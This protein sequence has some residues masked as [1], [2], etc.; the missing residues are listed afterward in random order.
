MDFEYPKE[1]LLK[2]PELYKGGLFNIHFNFASFL[3]WIFFAFFKAI[4]LIVIS[5]HEFK[6]SPKS[7][8]GK[9]AGYAELGDF[10]FAC[11]VYVVNIKILVC[12]NGIGLGILLTIG[13]SIL[14]YFASHCIL[15]YLFTGWD[16]FGTMDQLLSHPYNYLASLLFICLFAELDR[17]ASHVGKAI[18]D[19][20]MVR[21]L[22]A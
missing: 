22:K 17:A 9:M 4:I 12:S 16:H 14:V 5:V 7:S 13:L 15:S 18:K 6:L 21:R 11:I 1:H 19:F 10:V 2:N 20:K 3:R 8:N